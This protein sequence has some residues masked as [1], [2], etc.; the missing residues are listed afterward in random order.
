VLSGAACQT[1]RVRYLS[2]SGEAIVTGDA[3]SMTLEQIAPRCTGSQHPEM[4]L[5]TQRSSTSGTPHG[6][7]GSSG[8]I[9]GHAKS[10][11]SFG[12]FRA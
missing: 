3:S 1:G 8:S 9:M 7:S 5:N 6:L 2:P 4:P 11:S 10:A 12:S